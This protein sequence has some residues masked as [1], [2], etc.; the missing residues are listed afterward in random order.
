MSFRRL[1]SLFDKVEWGG[2]TF[3]G[4]DVLLVNGM[5]RNFDMSIY[6]DYTG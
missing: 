1:K 6:N 5:G 2:I 3:K 4:T